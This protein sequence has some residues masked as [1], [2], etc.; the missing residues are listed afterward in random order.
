VRASPDSEPQQMPQLMGNVREGKEMTQQSTSTRSNPTKP[1]LN[2][3]PLWVFVVLGLVGVSLIAAVVPHPD[4]VP[5]PAPQVALSVLVGA[6][7]LL[8]V[9]NQAVMQ[10]YAYLVGRPLQP[11]GKPHLATPQEGSMGAVR[12]LLDPWINRTIGPPRSAARVRSYLLL[13]ATLWLASSLS[14]WY[15]YYY[16]DRS[17]HGRDM[18]RL[19]VSRITYLTP[20]DVRNLPTKKIDDSWS[21]PC[22]TALT[23]ATATVLAEETNNLSLFLDGLKTIDSAALS[24]LV[25]RR[26]SLSLDGLGE[27]TEK[28]AAILSKHYGG[29]LSL[30]GVKSL[31]NEV[32]K[33]LATHQG[34]IYLRGLEE[35]D[36]EALLELQSVAILSEH[37]K[38]AQRSARRDAFLH[39]R[40]SNSDLE[41]AAIEPLPPQSDRSANEQATKP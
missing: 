24:R 31:S 6:G 9:F 34:H 21:F 36:D 14:S 40:K 41:E 25:D 19:D 33:A 8:M 22:V 39:S 23:P 37:L 17:D 28:Q 7:F 5:S 13:G 26:G 18:S 27:L 16:P 2:A 38:E 3:W 12:R 29:Y 1:R 20:G 10:S 32:A 15:A 11:L 4:R 35:V 30:D